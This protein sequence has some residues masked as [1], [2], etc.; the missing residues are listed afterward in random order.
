[1]SKEK[2]FVIAK[3]QP[4]SKAR[5]IIALEVQGGAEAR[6]KGF[7]NFIPHISTLRSTLSTAVWNFGNCGIS[8]TAKS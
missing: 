7:S 8:G 5:R 4:A 6:P 1:L 2:V 3:A